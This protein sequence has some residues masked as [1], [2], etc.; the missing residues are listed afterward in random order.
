M[1]ENCPLL[2]W[3]VSSSTD[4][5]TG[6]FNELGKSI[7]RSFDAYKVVGNNGWAETAGSPLFLPGWAS[8]FIRLLSFQG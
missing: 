8:F 2:V 6:T 1:L 5:F 7:E 3:A 4:A